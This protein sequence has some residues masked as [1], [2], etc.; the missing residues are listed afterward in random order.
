MT[1]KLKVN[2]CFLDGIRE[3]GHKRMGKVSV[4]KNGTVIYRGKRSIVIKK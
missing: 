1:P 2:E 3:F 4:V